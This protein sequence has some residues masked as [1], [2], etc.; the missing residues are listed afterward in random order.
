M[1]EA[2][3]AHERQNLVRHRQMRS[4]QDRQADAIDTVLG[5]LDDL[6]RGEPNAVVDHVHAGVGGAHR[7]LFGA[8]GMA[9]EAGFADE[10][11]Q[12][13]AELQRHALDLAAQGIEIGRLLARPGADAGRRAI[14]AEFGA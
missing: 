7:D 6:L 3:R 4:R 12:A 14:F 1:A 13:V 9:V 5:A 10:E 2:G 8:V 11:L